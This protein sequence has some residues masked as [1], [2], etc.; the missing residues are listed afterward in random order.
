MISI[1]PD[2]AT[3]G[4]SAKPLGLGGNG[5]SW[6]GEGKSAMRSRPPR[7]KLLRLKTCGFLVNDFNDPSE[8][9]PHR[10]HVLP[11]DARLGGQDPSCLAMYKL[12]ATFRGESHFTMNAEFK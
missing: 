4:A 6:G 3:P 5:S 8:A 1:E 11:H 9:R 2:L 7:S 12:R 10:A